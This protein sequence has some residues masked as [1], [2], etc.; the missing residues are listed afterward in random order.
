MKNDNLF[1]ESQKIARQFDDATLKQD[2]DKLRELILSTEKDLLS[3]NQTVIL[4]DY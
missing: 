2:V 4:N 3:K 1:I